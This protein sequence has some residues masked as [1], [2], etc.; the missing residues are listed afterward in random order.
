MTIILFV[1]V[2]LVCVIVHEW[3]HFIVAKKSGMLVQEFGFGI[4]PRLWGKKKGE[5]LYSINALPIGGFVKIAGENDLEE[6]IPVDRQFE[7]KAWWQKALVLVAGVVMNIVLALV[8]FFFAYIVGMS[9]VTDGGTP[10][11]VTVAPQSPAAGAGLQVGDTLQSLAIDDISVTTLSTEAVHAAIVAGGTE[12]VL[13]YTRDGQQYRVTLSPEGEGESRMIGLGIEPIGVIKYSVG[14]AARA[15]WQHTWALI[16][17][18]WGVLADLVSGLFS[19][20]KDAGLSNLMGPVGL[21][22]EVR[23]AATIGFAYLLAFTAA[24]SVNLAVLNIMPF[25]ALDGGRLIIVLLEALF[26]R[27]FSRTAVGYIHAAGFI[28]L[29]LLMVVLTV[30]DIR[31]FL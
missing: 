15:S 9:T 19:S 11:I 7:S 1:L 29:I 4:P 25:P 20:G 5:T 17:A 2:L 14:E 30:G 31:N 21:A 10:T 22:R 27:K 3:G 26:G 18:I 16:S 23:G 13:T 28:L 8:L 6:G 24:I 12:V